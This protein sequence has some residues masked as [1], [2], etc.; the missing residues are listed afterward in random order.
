MLSFH[1][2]TQDLAYPI[3]SMAQVLFCRSEAA[4]LGWT[5]EDAQQMYYDAIA[6]SIESYGVTDGPAGDGVGGY[7]DYITNSEVVWTATREMEQIAT[8]K[9]VAL[10]LVGYEGWSNW[11]RTGWPVLQPSPNGIQSDVIPI[12]QGYP[13]SERDLNA[14]NWQAALD[15]QFGGTDD[16]NGKLWLFPNS[17]KWEDGDRN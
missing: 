4:M 11:R 14:V 3:Y 7:S 16:L 6:A 2:R 12:R 17:D 1:M 8:Q 13:D 5:T 10:Y 15:S 9:W